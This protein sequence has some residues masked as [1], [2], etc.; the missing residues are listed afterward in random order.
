MS[1]THLRRPTAIAAAAG[2][3]LLAAALLASPGSTAAATSPASAGSTTT[4]IKHVV[5]IYQENVS[6]DHY[7]ATYPK[8]ANTDGTPFVAH[9]TVPANDNLASAGLLTSNPNLDGPQRLGPA[10]ALTCDQDHGYRAEQLAYDGGKMD[11]FVENTSRDACAGLYGAPGLVMDYYDGNTTTAL[12]NYANNFAMSDNSFSSTFGPSTP[13]ALNLISGQTHGFVEI[14]PTT[15]R[16]VAT[17]GSYVLA[18]PDG[19]G[20]G[21][22]I[23]DPDPAY[24]DCS[25]KSR[26]STHTLAGDEGKGTNVGDLL[27]AKGVT[28]G[29]FEGGF[30]PTSYTDG[31]ANCLSSHANI[32]G[33]VQTDYNP[34]HE[35]FQYYES[36]ANPHHLPPSS[37][38]AVGHTDQANHQYDLSDFD[39][40]LADDNLPAVSFLKAANYQDGHAAYS[41]PI[42]EQHF[43]VKY[44]NMIQ[45][46]QY[47]KDTAIV[48]AYDDSDGWYDH[49]ASPVLNASQDPAQ[50]AAWCSAAG[51]PVA[52]GYQDRCGPGPRQPLLVISP[53]AKRNFIDHTATEQASILKLIEDNW[54]TGTLGDGSFDERAGSLGSMFDF[55][56]PDNRKVLL[57]DNGSVLGR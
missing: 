2:T 32:G 30:K 12:W 54:S 47:W 52:A 13:G 29:W 31:R 10:Q 27:N 35:P 44:I 18:S 57:R 46:S 5:V 56:A 17:P 20:V 23:N 3:T 50:D 49:V 55:A 22:I 53:Y 1:I 36:T 6:Y 26:T 48:I 38:A 19:S 43:L 41:D 28:W 25:N 33:A 8:A 51:A 15:G 21:T 24:D 9:G 39:A 42:D 4:P 45:R 7:F 40:A 14:D 16:Q 34:H 37:V 11:K